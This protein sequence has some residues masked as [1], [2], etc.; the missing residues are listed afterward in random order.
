MNRLAGQ[1]NDDKETY[2]KNAER[3]RAFGVKIYEE[4]KDASI[5]SAV[6]EFDPESIVSR[7]RGPGNH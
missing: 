4:P 2:K 3:L 1:M 7:Y 6:E 5:T